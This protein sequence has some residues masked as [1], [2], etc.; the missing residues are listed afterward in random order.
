MIDVLVID[1]TDQIKSELSAVQA[2]VSCVDDEV[3]ALNVLE[4][5][6]SVVVL[7]N[8]NMMQEQTAEYTKVLVKANSA[9]SIVVIADELTEKEILNCL[10]AGA[11][12]YQQLSQLKEY[13]NKLVTVMDAGEAWIT[14]RMTATLLD[15]LRQ[16]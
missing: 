15:S 5:S 7:L 1:K 3:K 6:S 12:G 8:F 4:Q 2:N 11:K 14:R 13:S 10:L 16:R 9:C